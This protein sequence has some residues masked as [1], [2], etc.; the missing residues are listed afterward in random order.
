MFHPKV[1][2]VPERKNRVTTFIDL[3]HDGQLQVLPVVLFTVDAKQD[4]AQFGGQPEGRQHVE[5]RQRAQGGRQLLHGH[6]ALLG[7]LEGQHIYD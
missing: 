7:V 1:L 5:V 3:A 2:M 4:S 6:E